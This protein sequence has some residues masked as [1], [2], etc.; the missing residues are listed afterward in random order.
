MR[1]AVF[2]GPHR[3]L[4][5]EDLTPIDPGPHDVVVRVMASGLC[6]SDLNAIEGKSPLPP[7]AILGHEGAGVVEAV[8][9]DVS[10]FRVGD[11]VIGS[12]FP[13]CGF[14]WWCLHDKSNLCDKLAERMVVDRAT[15]PDG[16]HVPGMAGLGTFAE[17]M[18]CH[19]MSLVRVETDLP[20]EQLALLGCGVTTG[21]GAALNS[22]RVEPGSSVVIIGC[23]GVGQGVLQG[24]RI[25]GAGRIIVVD[26]AIF[27]R[28]MA[29]E[30]G[31]T[32]VIDPGDVDVVEAVKVLTNGLGADYAF[33]VTGIP[34]LLMQAFACVRKA[35]T[36]I[37]IGMSGP[38]AIAM[39][40]THQLIMQ[41]KRLIGS[42]FGSANV[43]R[44]FPRLISFMESGKLDVAGMVT[45]SITLDEVNDGFDLMKAGTVIRS[46]IRF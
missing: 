7:P 1:A 40:P 22:A 14:C 12:M 23:G 8:G 32:D 37:A 6:H 25:A 42:V 4:S 13:V 27:K 19:Q 36:A 5:L 9:R 11:R 43:R 39:V 21:V 17:T 20:Y 31:A 26:P 34:E 45:K 41:E 15:C 46:V 10:G 29:L 30:Q 44:E 33:E 16:T 2:R 28:E 18:T 3:P 24:A 38:T 35:G